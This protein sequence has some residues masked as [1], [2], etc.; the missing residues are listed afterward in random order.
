MKPVPPARDPRIRD[1]AGPT[2][3]C[4]DRNS[5]ASYPEKVRQTPDTSRRRLGCIIDLEPAGVT[6]TP[7]FSG[8]SLL[9]GR[10]G[11]E[12]PLLA[13]LKQSTFIDQNGAV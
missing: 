4:Q 5:Y 9:F 11:I 10:H 13:V 12:D 7:L 6:S 1:R 3:S 8:P 2:A